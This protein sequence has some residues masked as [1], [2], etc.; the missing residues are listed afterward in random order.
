MVIPL[1]PHQFIAN[2]IRLTK[3]DGSL[4]HDGSF[5][6]QSLFQRTGGASGIPNSS[7][8]AI[9]AAGVGQTD[10]KLL[11]DDF[12]YVTTGS[13]GVILKALQPGQ[14]Q[15]VH[16]ATLGN[17]NVYPASSGQINAL[18][19]NAPYVLA[20]GTMQI[21]WVPNLLPTTGGTFYKTITLG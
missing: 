5:F 10:A 6:M 12:N 8:A 4:D 9:A 2:K 17:L 15:W 16:N 18:A 21:F 14:L 13:G 19:V 1:N 7:N 3:R 20:T 11:T